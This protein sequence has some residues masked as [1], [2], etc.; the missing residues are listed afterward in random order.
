MSY[1]HVGNTQYHLTIIKSPNLSMFPS[2]NNEN[3]KILFLLKRIAFKIKCKA[4][5][6][7]K[8]ITNV[9]YCY[10]LLMQTSLV[11]CIY[12]YHDFIVVY[13]SRTLVPYQE[14]V[15]S[16]LQLRK[17]SEMLNNIHV[18]KQWVKCQSHTSKSTVISTFSLYM[19]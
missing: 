6:S 17:L 11:F 12:R 5:Y 10:I 18:V 1:G 2:L 9:S 19:P 7:I 14:I 13:P 4:L 16:L 15:F 8:F 3:N